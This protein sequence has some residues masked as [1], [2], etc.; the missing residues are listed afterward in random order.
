MEPVYWRQMATGELG[1]HTKSGR[2]VTYTLCDREWF[3]VNYTSKM[4]KEDVA[5]FIGF[6]TTVHSHLKG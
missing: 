3:K 6:L 5:E 1:T 2:T 4:S